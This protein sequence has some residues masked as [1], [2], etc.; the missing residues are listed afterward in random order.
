[1]K[2]RKMIK[3]KLDFTFDSQAK[4]GYIY[5]K[6]PMQDGEIT[7]QIEMEDKENKIHVV[8]DFNKDN[9]LVGIELLSFGKLGIDLRN[10][11]QNKDDI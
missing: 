10:D 8:F 2:S 7:K 9:E 3:R 1:M 6:S 5:F 4:V 11:S